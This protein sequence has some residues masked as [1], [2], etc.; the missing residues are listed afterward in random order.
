MP[1]VGFY[2]LSNDV[3]HLSFS[4]HDNLTKNLKE[5]MVASADKKFERP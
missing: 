1:Y 4:R 3:S 5:N 2:E